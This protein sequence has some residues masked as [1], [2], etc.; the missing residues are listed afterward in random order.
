MRVTAG[1]AIVLLAALAAGRVAAGFPAVMGAVASGFASQQGVYRTRASAMFWTASAMA[2]STYIGELAGHSLIALII[3]TAL[4]G[5]AYGIVA[6]LGPTATTIGVNSVIALVIYG[7]YPAGPI[8]GLEPALLVLAGGLVQTFLIVI[9]WPLR[10]FS[11]ERHGLAHVARALA[12]YA[13]EIAGGSSAL[14]SFTPFTTVRQTLLDPQ[15]FARRGDIAVFQALLDEM[16]RIRGGLA[17]LATDRALASEPRPIDEFALGIAGILSEVADA[18]DAA[19]EPI[20]GRNEWVRVRAA[21]DALEKVSA[22]GA[23]VRSEAHALAGQLRSIWRLAT[24]PA[25]IPVPAIQQTP[26]EHSSLAIDDTLAT[27]RANLTQGSPYGRLAPRVAG[28]LAVATI[29]GGTLP[30]QHGYWIPMTAVILLRPDFSQT[31]LRGIG[32]VAGTIIGAAFATAIAAHIRP[33]PETYVALTI[34]FSGLSF[35]LFRANYGIFSITITAYVAFALALLGQTE[36]VALRDRVLGTVV[37]GI[38]TGV[39]VF[40]WPTWESGRVR[41]ALANL[42]EAQRAYLASVLLAYLDPENF[43]ARRITEAQRTAWSLRASAEASVDRMLGE[44][45]RTHAIAPDLALGILAASRRI[46]L[47][48]LSL[49]AHYPHAEHIARP[50]LEPLENA[51][52]HALAFTI[53]LMRGERKTERYP[54][55]REAYRAARNQLHDPNAEMILAVGDALVNATNTAAELAGGKDAG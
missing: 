2:I 8:V 52:D 19:K 22:G 39:A 24:L 27:L 54:H 48:T 3:V 23:H 53:S 34:V 5:Y 49:N 7:H 31:A 35:Y 43:D 40:V 9:V 16:E 26:S 32:R 42:L 37:A 38:L 14:P 46:G 55:L 41:T 44:P 28:S 50:G 29:L 36:A 18:L 13:L 17:A 10:R 30:T 51:L 12:A 20:D 47:A 21:E 6:S 1:V 45:G 15:P 33:G 25:D 4:W 11:Q